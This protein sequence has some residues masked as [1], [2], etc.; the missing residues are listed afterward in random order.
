LRTIGYAA[1]RTGNFVG[2]RKYFERALA[3]YEQFGDAAHPDALTVLSDIGAACSAMGDHQ[4]AFAAHDAVLHRRRATLDEFHYDIGIS[5]HNLGAVLS[6]LGDLDAAEQHHDEAVSLWRTTLGA[7]HPL[8]ARG[9]ASLSALALRRGRTASATDYARQVLA[10]RLTALPAGDAAI[11]GARDALATCLH[12]AGE[13]AEACVQWRAAIADMAG[14]DAASAARLHVKIGTAQRQAGQLADAAGSF[15]AAVRDDDTLTAAHHALAAALTRLGRD[16]EAKPHR[17]TALRQQRI[18]TEGSAPHAPC[19][20]ILSLADDGNIP[21]DHILPAHAFTRIWWFIDHA[22]DAAAEDLPRYDI[23][24]NAIGDPDMSAAADAKI[25]AFKTVCRAP[26]LNDPGRVAATRRDRLPG[27]L[28]GI[29]DVSTPRVMRLG[30][31]PAVADV[32]AAAQA[33]GIGTPLLLRPAGKHGGKGV[34]RVDDWPE[35][36]RAAPDGAGDWYLAGLQDCRSDDG[37]FRKYRAIF[38][39]RIPYPYHLAISP[40]WLVHYFSSDMEA[41]DWKL[42]EEAGFLDD[43]EAALGARAW[44]ALCQ[45]GRRID[46]DYCGMDF[47]VRP[48]GTV[49]VFEANATMLVHPERPGTKLAFKNGAVQRIIEAVR[50]LIALR[51]G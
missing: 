15:A 37:F 21:L 12:H 38:V 14:R 41:H 51:L 48:D 31:S 49:L 30:P 47:T 1:Y 29:A 6:A 42:A 4:A 27:L 8:V 40:H 22:P 32:R 10:I 5:L 2:A 7:D 45:A 39:D 9:L 18:F 50:A 35:L 23:V 26:L 20:L 46:L 19:V 43:P 11:I 13:Y 34:V 25:A 33:G 17:E 3:L 28:D 44:A 24:L 16:E 36:D